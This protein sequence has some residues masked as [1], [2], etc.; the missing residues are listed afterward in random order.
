M[1]TSEIRDGMLAKIISAPSFNNG[2]AE[3]LGILNRFESV[4][5]SNLY[6]LEGF[7][8]KLIMVEELIEKYKLNGNDLNSEIAFKELRTNVDLIFK[9]KGIFSFFNMIIIKLFNKQGIQPLDNSE[10]NKLI[11]K[12]KEIST[13]AIW[14]IVV[15]VFIFAIMLH[16]LLD[17]CPPNSPFSSLC[18][19]VVS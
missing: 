18:L 13:G 10:K 9:P 1:N 16:F 6:A 5:G 19:K 3:K 7:L 4:R 17:T 8:K 2:Y 11:Y 14:S 15:G 12:N